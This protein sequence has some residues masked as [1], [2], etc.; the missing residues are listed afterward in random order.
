[1]LKGNKIQANYL[2]AGKRFE[3]LLYKKLRYCTDCKENII[4]KKI[5][6]I[7]EFSPDFNETTS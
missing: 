2:S 7:K 4:C 6:Q 1:M 3:S 5:N